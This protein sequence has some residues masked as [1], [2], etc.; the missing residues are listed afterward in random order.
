[1]VDNFIREAIRLHREGWTAIDFGLNAGRNI[2]RID[3]LTNNRSWK[4]TDKKTW[5]ALQA[6]DKD[7][8]KPV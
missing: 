8:E 3:K 5:L 6:L 1:M 2:L 7:N 4:E